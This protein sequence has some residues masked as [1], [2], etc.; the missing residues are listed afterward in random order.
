MP[1]RTSKAISIA[2]NKTPGH[3]FKIGE[4]RENLSK[5]VV[6]IESEALRSV[7][8]GSR[9]KPT[10]VCVSYERFKP[11]LEHGNRSEKLVVRS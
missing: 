2:G 5:I 11:M 9:G 6:D 8:V 10:M 3:V 4:A 1:G 7:V